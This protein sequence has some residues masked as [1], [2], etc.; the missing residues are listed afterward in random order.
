MNRKDGEFAVK[1]A[2]KTIENW[3]SEREVPER[4]GASGIFS[5]KSGVFT[6]IHT[7][8][9]HALRGCIGLPYPDKPLLDAIVESAVSVTEDPRFPP[10]EEKELENIIVEVSVLSAPRKIVFKNPE[11]CPGKIEIGK[12]GLVIK[13]GFRSGLLLPQVATEN[14]F[15]AEKFLECLCWKAGLPKDGWKDGKCEILKFQAHIFSEETPGGKVVE[16]TTG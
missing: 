11:E 3:V 7:Y 13:S 10:L 1:L 16:K 2:R 6:T 5:R 9:G 4:P 14:K 12:D 8:P 15:D